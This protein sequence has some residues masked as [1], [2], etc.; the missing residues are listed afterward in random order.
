MGPY[1]LTEWSRKAGKDYEMKLDAN[2]SYFGAADVKNQHI[3]IKFYSD[4]T[5]LALAIKSGD[6]DMAFRQ[7]ASTDIK[8]MQ[9]DPTV[10]VWVGTGA[11]IQ[12]ICFQEKIA[13]FDDPQFRQAF[14]AALDRTTLTQTVFLGQANPLFSMI[15][16]GM[17]FQ[18]DAYKTLGDAN[19]TPLTTMLTQMGYTPTPGMS[20]TQQIGLAMLVIGIVILVAGL[21]TSRRKKA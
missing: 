13:P 12:Y 4:A 20:S 10:K 2:P 16:N 21:A 19:T 17:A 14:A 7:L 5:A 8:N 3:I 1:L 9:T 6:I 11:F 15:P 18:T